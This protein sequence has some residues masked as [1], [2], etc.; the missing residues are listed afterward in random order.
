M[1]VTRLHVYAS[2]HHE[3]F[4]LTRKEIQRESLRQ[5]LR[6]SVENDNDPDFAPDHC[7]DRQNDQKQV[8]R[9]SPSLGRQIKRFGRFAEIEASPRARIEGSRWRDMP[10]ITGVAPHPGRCTCYRCLRVQQSV[11]IEDDR[12]TFPVP[13]YV[14]TAGGWRTVEA[15]RLT[16]FGRDL[17]LTLD[18]GTF[19]LVK[20]TETD[21]RT[22]NTFTYDAWTGGQDG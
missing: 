2:G 19:V 17:R 6:R 13:T 3:T 1:T 7:W 14:E 4:E 16:G 8:V 21:E 5:L 12:T 9:R 18:C 22:G 15:E 10:P 11:I 20:R